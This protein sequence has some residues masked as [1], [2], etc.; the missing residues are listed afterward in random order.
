MY[1]QSAP[2]L[3]RQQ[4]IK[5]FVVELDNSDQQDEPFTHLPQQ[6]SLCPARERERERHDNGALAFNEET[7]A[8]EL[9][10]MACALM[11]RRSSLL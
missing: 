7:P 3:Y 10:G 5:L 8:R 11:I 9:S 1:H 6:V 4:H 2:N